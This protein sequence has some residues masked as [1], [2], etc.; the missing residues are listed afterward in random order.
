MSVGLVFV[1]MGVTVGLVFVVLCVTVGL[2]LAVVFMDVGLLGVPL[3]GSSDFV[4]KQTEQSQDLLL[5]GI[6]FLPRHDK[7][8]NFPLAVAP[9]TVT[10]S[11]PVYHRASTSGKTQILQN[12]C[13]LGKTLSQWSLCGRIFCETSLILFSF[14]SQT[15]K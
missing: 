13:N 6:L 15:T 8:K 11:L 9:S 1:V 3:M 5:F 2:V 10:F 12:L 14:T 7:W 4:T